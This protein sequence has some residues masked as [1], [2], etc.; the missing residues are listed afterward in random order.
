MKSIVP[1]YHLVAMRTWTTSLLSTATGSQN[2][3]GEKAA[4]YALQATP[5]LLAATLLTCANVKKMFGTGS[6]GDRWTDK[7]V[8]AQNT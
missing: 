6:W 8:E 3:A 5:E 4:F 1:I 7:K 2:T